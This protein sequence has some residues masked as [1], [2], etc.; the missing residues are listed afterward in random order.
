ME[1]VFQIKA[2]SIAVSY[3]MTCQ[4][5]RLSIV[6]EECEEVQVEKQASELEVWV[7]HQ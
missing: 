4:V 2:V 1:R 5:V 3:P 7:S 6:G